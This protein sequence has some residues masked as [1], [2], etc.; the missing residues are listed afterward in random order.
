M[1]SP[2][3]VQPILLVNVNSPR[4][5]AMG[6]LNN[7]YIRCYFIRITNDVIFTQSKTHPITLVLLICSDNLL[8]INH[9]VIWIMCSEDLSTGYDNH[10][11]TQQSLADSRLEALA[12]SLIC[13]R[14]S[15]GP[16][17]KPW[18]TPHLLF[19]ILDETPPLHVKMRIIIKI[20]SLAR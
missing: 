17:I 10:P 12:I 5:C 6:L 14:T 9:Y 3:K 7:V 4:L 19:K 2:V 18:A 11:Q 8:A 1:I 20:R 16:S 13:K 15:M